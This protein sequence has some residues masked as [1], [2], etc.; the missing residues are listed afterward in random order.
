[1]QTVNGIGGIFFK[2]W[3]DNPENKPT[4]DRVKLRLPLLGR[5][6]SARFYVQFLETMANLVANGLPLLRSLPRASPDRSE[7]RSRTIRS[8]SS[9]MATTSS[10][11]TRT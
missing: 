2:A 8:T 6:I 3:L 11:W 7:P 5:V 1:M 9:S 4:W 10:R